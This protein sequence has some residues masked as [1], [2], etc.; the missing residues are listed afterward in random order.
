[1]PERSKYEVY[2]Y[3]EETVYDYPYC[4]TAL[5]SWTYYLVTYL[6][7]RLQLSWSPLKAIM[8][9]S[10]L[11]LAATFLAGAFAVPL[12]N[13]MSYYTSILQ[14]FVSVGGN[15]GWKFSAI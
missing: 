9:F 6:P 2:K 11:Y 12:P 8:L 15:E 13:S 7:F 5:S 1:M 10:K 3:L 14:F 4:S